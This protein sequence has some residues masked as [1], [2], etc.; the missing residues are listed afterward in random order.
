MIGPQIIGIA[1]KT[2]SVGKSVVAVNLATMLS[3]NGKKVLLVDADPS[4]PSVDLYMGLL[5]A[6]AD[7][8]NLLYDSTPAENSTHRY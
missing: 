2:N 8:T 5:T 4:G 7:Y 6:A 3:L 1:S